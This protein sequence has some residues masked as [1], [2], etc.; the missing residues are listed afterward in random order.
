MPQWRES[1]KHVSSRSIGP[2]AHLCRRLSVD[3]DATSLP[4]VT[5][6]HADAKVATVPVA[7][8]MAMAKTEAGRPHHQR[9]ASRVRVQ[10]SSTRNDVTERLSDTPP[11]DAVKAVA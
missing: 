1:R 9:R 6:T 5:R 11:T 4:M 2:F 7:M 8:T 10:L 3:V